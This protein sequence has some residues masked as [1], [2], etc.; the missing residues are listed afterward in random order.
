MVTCSNCGS[1]EV[2]CGLDRRKRVWLWS[3]LSFLPAFYWIF[4]PIYLFIGAAYL[5][6]PFTGECVCRNCGLI[7]S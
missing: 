2:Y 6:I 4:L 5:L 7:L 3:L 1:E